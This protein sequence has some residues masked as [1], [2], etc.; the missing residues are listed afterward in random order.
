MSSISDYSH[1][2]IMEILMKRT[3]LILFFSTISFGQVSTSYS[4]EDGGTILSFYGNVAN[5][6]NV[7]STGGV[8]PYDGAVMLTVSESPL[9][10]TPQAFI[11]FIENLSPGDVVT[12]SYYGYD[13]SQGTSPSLRI[14]GSYATNGDIDG[15]SGSAGGSG[16]YTSGNGW[17]QLSY[18]WTID[19]G[20]EA[21]VIQARLYS[22]SDD[23]TIYFIDLVSVTAPAT[24]TVTYPSPSSP[25]ELTADA[26][27]DQIVSVDA[28]VI[29]DGSG[30]SGSIVSYTWTQ[31]GT[32]TVILNN[33]N[34]DTATFTAPGF[35]VEL[36]FELA[37]M[38]DGNTER[39]TVGIDV[40]EISSG[41][42]FISEYIEGDGGTQKYL[43]IYNNSES[44]IDLQ[45]GFYS[46]RRT[47]DGNG[48]FT[49]YI[50]DDWGTNNLLPS[51]EVLVLAAE[52]SDLYSN[53]DMILPHNSPLH[54]NG[55]DAVGLFV[56]GV[57]VDLIGEPS[58][59]GD[60]IINV[61]LRRNSSV[62]EPNPIYTISEWT[63]LE[64]NNVSGLGF[65]NANTDA[66]LLS[67][68]SYSP[69][70]VTSSTELEVSADILPVVGTIASASIW[71]G[72]DG[73]MLNEAEMWFEAGDTWAGLI[74]PQTGNSILQFKV[75]G[76]DNSGNLGE[77]GTS[78]VIIASSTPNTIADI[79]ADVATYI[80]EMVT[81]R[82][83]VTIGAGVIKE[84]ET[85]AYIQDNSGR[86]I[87]IFDFD[88]LPNIDRGDELL[89][90]GYVDQFITTTEIT[91]FSFT[92]LSSGNNLPTAA[93]L[94][95]AQAN[96][97]NYEG[98]FIS[99]GGTISRFREI[100]GG[101]KLT[102]MDG[103]DSTFV[104][105][106]GSTG[107]DVTS[108][109]V[110]SDWSFSGVGS[111]YYDDFQLLVGYADDIT[112]LGIEDNVE[113]P[114]TFGLH[115]AYPNPF[116]PSTTVSW[117]LDHSGEHELSIY[118]I[119][120]QRV[121]VLSSGYMPAGSFT[122]TWQANELSSGVYFI[123]LTSEHKNDIHK[124]LL[125][126]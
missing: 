69:E 112:T 75:S 51:G 17:E 99:V 76:T 52:L 107:I 72:T 4:W 14:W 1:F 59:S 41:Q 5:P 84:D 31:I 126:K 65:H 55:N 87:N 101:T 48:D 105:I 11:A 15:Y 54:F 109:T 37:V 60:I 56:N 97:P 106:W 123:Q 42:V 39:D 67:N 78:S 102:L 82:G 21:L 7:G 2:K 83:I 35:A 74:P 125:V 18:T 53:P 86:G 98:T 6:G 26:G 32:P 19:A 47:D 95:V 20:K 118:N 46:L 116:N 94:T 36:Q 124:I 73:S 63:I 117:S 40:L 115:T 68:I 22:G 12:A 44:T 34:N 79:Q 90:V 120:G 96:S 16:A 9:S 50:F 61:T 114:I 24:A 104:M 92:M 30:S 80:G 10:G 25:P 81:I 58:N 33:A 64:V 38:D 13:D 89:M 57:L 8:D 108:I 111:Q 100:T 110:G 49:S 27:P 43:E 103:N 45:A 28:S 29:L 85:R 91:D 62:T 23:P 93:E 88:L 113:L 122:S 121:D 77:S 70:F 119:L 66:P 3:L 71:Y